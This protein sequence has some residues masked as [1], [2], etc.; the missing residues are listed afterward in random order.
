[1]YLWMSEGFLVTFCT[2]LRSSGAAYR[3][4]QILIY[5]YAVVAITVRNDYLVGN[6]SIAH[7]ASVK[8]P[9]LFLMYV[10]IKCT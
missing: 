2:Q 5:V 8:L 3:V 1:M 6:A 9:C 7:H 10:F 4:K